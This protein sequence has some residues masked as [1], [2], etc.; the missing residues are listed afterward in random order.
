MALWTRARELALA[1][2][3]TWLNNDTRAQNALINELIDMDEHGAGVNFAIDLL[4][5]I[6]IFGVH[7]GMLRPEVDI[8][9]RWAAP[10]NATA[11][12]MVAHCECIQLI[13]D[14]WSGLASWDHERAVAAKSKIWKVSLEQVREILRIMAF[15]AALATE[16]FSI[17]RAIGSETWEG[18]RRDNPLPGAPEP[19]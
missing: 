12:E 15:D 14:L 18:Y 17:W 16:T 6:R 13:T 4:T 7:Q 11:E 5:S 8:A 19:E 3:Y 2:T 9:P 1:A 10:E